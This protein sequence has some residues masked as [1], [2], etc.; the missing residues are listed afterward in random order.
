METTE[1]E[2]EVYE[3]AGGL[4]SGLLAFGSASTASEA[5]KEGLHYLSQYGLGYKL[6][7]SEVTRKVIAV[8]SAVVK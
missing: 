8:H 4:V 7:V 5:E 3:V 6:E 2:W 1:Y